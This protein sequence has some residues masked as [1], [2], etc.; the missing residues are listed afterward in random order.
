MSKI[1]PKR[2]H[3]KE[4]IE[5][6]LGLRADGKEQASAIENFTNLRLAPDGS[7]EKRNGWQLI[8]DIP[9]KV[10]GERLTTEDFVRLSDA[11][12]EL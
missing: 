10:R 5:K 2:A 3:A 12:H 6:F 4:I 11:I 9:E 1:Q 8:G 7:V